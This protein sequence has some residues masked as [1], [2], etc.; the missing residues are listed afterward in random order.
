VGSGVIVQLNGGRKG[1]IRRQE[2]SW[3]RSLKGKELDYS[4]GDE[5]ETVVL[6]HD[7]REGLIELSLKRAQGDPWDKI[8]RGGYRPGSVVPGEVVNLE[9]YG[10]FVEIEPGVVGLLHKSAIPGAQDK[11]IYDLLWVGDQVEVVI[12]TL[13]DQKHRIGLSIIE[14]LRKRHQEFDQNIKV[15]SQKLPGRRLRAKYGTADS[16]R[17]KLRQRIRR[18]LIVDDDQE[19]SQGFKQWLKRYEYEVQCVETGR[20]ALPVVRDFDLVFLDMNLPDT[21]GTTLAGDLVG[22][23]SNISIVLIT[24]QDQFTQDV[25]EFDGLPI[26]DILFKPI[27][28]TDL[29]NV[30]VAAETGALFERFPRLPA[31]RRMV[32]TGFLETT[33]AQS[34]NFDGFREFSN[35]VLDDLRMSLD[36]QTVLLFQVDVFTHQI[37]IL[38]VS[39]SEVIA[40]Q[41]E[42]LQSLRFSIVINVALDEEMI[43][44][45][46][47]ADSKRFGS[48]LTFHYAESCLAVPVPVNVPDAR[49]ALFVLDREQDKFSKDVQKMVV[50]FSIFIAALLNENYITRQLQHAH[51]FALLGQLSSGLLHELRNKLNR[52]EQEAQLLELDCQDNLVITEPTVLTARTTQMAKRATRILAASA[53]LRELAKRYLG[54]IQKEE[55]L[56]VNINQIL[57]TTVK[58]LFP[59]AHV[60]KIHINTQFDDQLPLTRISSLRLEQVFLNIAVNAIQLMAQQSYPGQLQITSAYDIRDRD[61]PIKIRFID[62]GPGIHRKLWDWIFQLGTSTKEGGTGLGLFISQGLLESLGGRLS[63]EKSYMFVGSSFL[64]ELPVVSAQEVVDGRIQD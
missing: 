13:D 24:A 23:A 2:L 36:A 40:V 14:R 9:R 1:I 51:T 39:S 15:S 28:Y 54:L 41:H 19:F 52:I 49:Y 3:S 59:L 16:L 62:E 7:S 50:A 42:A 11:S 45:G 46:K 38:G 56:V 5:I 44:E 26:A 29:A 8:K 17:A 55:R 53:E 31:E 64:V 63:I 25:S 21:L 57:E 34:H 37:A 30:L 47:V 43:F 35:A 32:N 4:I 18:I 58:Q 60:N 20:D 27:D 6:S 61:R 33:S 10:A 48:F 12:E 22:R